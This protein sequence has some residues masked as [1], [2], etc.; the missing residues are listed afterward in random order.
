MAPPPPAGIIG[1]R[2]R[3]KTDGSPPSQP[4][5]T[6]AAVAEIFTARQIID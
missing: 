4:K 6:G 5:L 1:R 3:R 2:R